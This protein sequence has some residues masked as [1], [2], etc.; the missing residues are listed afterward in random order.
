MKVF[1]MGGITLLI[2]LVFGVLVSCTGSGV[3]V[4]PVAGPHGEFLFI[5]TT[6]YQSGSYGVYAVSQGVMSAANPSINSD[7][8]AT[9]YGGKVWVVNRFGQD[10]ILEVDPATGFQPTTNQF[11]VGAGANP[12]DI[13]FAS[14]TKAY[15]SRYDATTLW[16]VNPGTGQKI[17]EIDL[18]PFADA[19]DGKPEMAY[20]A[21]SGGRLFV[22]LQRLDRTGFPWTPAAAGAVVVIDTATDA[23]VDASPGVPGVNAIALA[24]QNP[25]TEWQTFNGRL[26]IGEQ[27]ALGVLDGGIERVN[28]TTLA[29]E[30]FL[31][32]ESALGGEITDFALGEG[33]GYGYAVVADATCST[34]PNFT[35]CN[36]HLKA[37]DPSTGSNV[38]NILDVNGFTLAKIALSGDASRLFVLDRSFTNP[39]LRV[40]RTVDDTELTVAPIP[41]GNLPPFWMVDFTLP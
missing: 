40:F 18:S 26:Y 2:V 20:M 5:V 37:F 22:A 32:S 39:G 13:E 33:R 6:D 1:S 28:P 41:T 19:A 15:V 34:P 23:V 29:P 36:M 25:T 4:I 11:S 14:M 8:T 38:R 35:P 24:G 30:G 17:G 27:G 7:A 21:M 10:N 31:V 9:F 16:I 3:T 12:Y